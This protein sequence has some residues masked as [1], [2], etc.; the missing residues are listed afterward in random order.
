MNECPIC[1]GEVKETK[2]ELSLFGGKIKYSAAGYEC[3]KC[4]EVFIDEEESKKIDS[5]VN[6]SSIRKLVDTLREHEFK[7]RRK[8]GYSGRTLIVRIP[9]DIERIIPLDEGEEVEIYPEGKNR[10]IIEKLTR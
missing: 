3:L 2:T 6:E 1:G 7:L 9:K 8:V 4:K 5:W 10:I